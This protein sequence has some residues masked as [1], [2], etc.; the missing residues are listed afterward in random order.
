M[1]LFKRVFGHERDAAGKSLD[2]VVLG[3]IVLAILVTLYAC[4]QLIGSR[5]F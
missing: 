4:P 3:F 5:S 1:S 2:R